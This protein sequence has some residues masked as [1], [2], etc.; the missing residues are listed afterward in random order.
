MTTL[1]L[2][3]GI[4]IA[5]VVVFGLAGCGLAAWEAERDE[6]AARIEEEG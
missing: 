5:L 6:I 1:L 2:G 3:I 4:V